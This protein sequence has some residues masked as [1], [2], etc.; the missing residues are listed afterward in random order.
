MAESSRHPNIV[1]TSDLPAMEMNQGKHRLKMRRLGA[2]TRGQMIGAMHTEVAPHSVSFPFHYHC[3][4]EEAIYV[5]SGSGL[6]RIG[7]A[8]VR[9]GAGDWIAFPPGPEHPHQMINDTDEPLVYVCVSALLQ[10]VDVVGYPD[11]RKVAASAGTFE[12]PI[13]R[14]ISKQGESLDYWADEPD[15][16]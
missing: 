5:L 8:R 7:D 14:W 1:N 13:H 9:I 15:A 6:A 2:A 12:K 11:S 16:G 10:K 4:T 3:A